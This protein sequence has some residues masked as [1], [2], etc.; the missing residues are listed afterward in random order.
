MTDPKTGEVL[1]MKATALPEEMASAL[2][3]WLRGPVFIVPFVSDE[4]EYLSA[5]VEDRFVIAQA[6][7]P[8]NEKTSLCAAVSSRY[9]SSFIFCQHQPSIIWTWP[10]TRSWASAPR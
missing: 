6:N 4:M 5:D 1:A 10:R 3:S 2:P 7:T 8:L 9:H